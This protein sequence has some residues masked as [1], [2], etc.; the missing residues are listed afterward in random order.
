MNC[1]RCTELE[2]ENE[3]LRDEADE[4]A[5]LKAQLEQAERY[6]QHKPGKLLDSHPIV[7]SARPDHVAPG[8]VWLNLNEFYITL[9][10][11]GNTWRCARF[12]KATS[13]QWCGA[14]EFFISV[15]DTKIF[16]MTYCGLF[17]PLPEE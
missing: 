10:R 5:K 1:N 14:T 12:S 11:R 17:H 4:A 15:P 7:T 8:Q 9:W 16:S 3:K 2:R 6:P 13:T